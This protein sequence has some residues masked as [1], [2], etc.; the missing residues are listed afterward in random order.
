[1]NALIHGFFNN[2][3]KNCDIIAGQNPVG[4]FA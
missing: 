2:E 1:M 3:N 4:S